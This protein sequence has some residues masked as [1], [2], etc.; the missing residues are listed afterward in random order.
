[1]EWGGG[2]GGVHSTYVAA[3]A[4]PDGALIGNF[5]HSSRHVEEM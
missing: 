5:F 1:M 3:V 4:M 2:E